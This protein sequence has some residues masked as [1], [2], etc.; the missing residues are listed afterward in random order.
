MLCS[1]TFARRP[2]QQRDWPASVPE[3]MYTNRAVGGPCVNV[4]I[5]RGYP[6]WEIARRTLKSNETALGSTHVGGTSMA[7]RWSRNVTPGGG[8]S[9]VIRKVRP[10]RIE[11]ADCR[12]RPG[13]G[14]DPVC[15]NPLTPLVR[16]VLSIHVRA[17][18]DEEPHLSN[19]EHASYHESSDP[20]GWAAAHAT[21]DLRA[22]ASC[23][24]RR[25]GCARS[26]TVVIARPCGRTRYIAYY[27]AAR[28]RTADGRGI[29]DVAARL[30][31][32]RRP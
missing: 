28:L 22:G 12:A 20:A 24:S 3:V 15:C 25:R 19:D 6:R 18:R 26:A 9:T 11:Q 13:F 30:R 14:G 10:E 29:P 21:A 27:H 32:V 16:V 1:G 4:P 7:P 17:C 8:W 2:Q 5:S 31:H 23:D